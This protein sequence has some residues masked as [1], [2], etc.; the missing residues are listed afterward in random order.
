M[1]DNCRKVEN[2]RSELDEL[3]K[4]GGYVIG[5]AA[6]I[7]EKLGLPGRGVRESIDTILGNRSDG[8]GAGQIELDAA[9]DGRDVK[10]EKIERVRGFFNPQP[11]KGVK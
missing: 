2:D 11:K 10:K 4:S 3:E 6:R 1:G 8:G 5:A 7:R 9:R